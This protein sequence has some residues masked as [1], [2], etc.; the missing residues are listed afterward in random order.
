MLRVG[1]MAR[2]REGRISGV[3]IWRRVPLRKRRGRAGQH[4]S[5]GRREYTYIP[6]EPPKFLAEVPEY[7]MVKAAL[8]TC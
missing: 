3:L 1:S 2:D 8:R 5:G 6:K 4:L 7:D